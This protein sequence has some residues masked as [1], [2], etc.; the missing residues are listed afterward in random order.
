MQIKCLYI[1]IHT[2]KSD[3]CT[4]RLKLTPIR[5]HPFT[6]F[7]NWHPHFAVSNGIHSVCFRTDQC[8]Q[9]LYVPAPFLPLLAVILPLIHSENHIIHSKLRTGMLPFI[10]FE[11]C[12]VTTHLRIVTLTFIQSKNCHVTTHSLWEFSYYYSFIVRIIML[13]FIH[14]ENCH[15]KSKC[16]NGAMLTVHQKYDHRSGKY[17]N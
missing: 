8:I 12:Q 11:K 17:Y 16:V 6:G 7:L 13:P 15:V 9:I 10:Q 2:I 4:I 3:L 5:L 1:C 14:S